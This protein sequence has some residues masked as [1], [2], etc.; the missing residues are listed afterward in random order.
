MKRSVLSPLLVGVCALV[1]TAGCSPAIP[2]PPGAPTSDLVL[3]ST[4]PGTTFEQ[5]SF[6]GK[7]YSAPLLSFMIPAGAHTVGVHYSIT[8]TDF[9][10]PEESFC[11]AT[12]S[13]G[14]CTGRLSAEAGASYRLLVDTRSSQ[15]RGT[16]S[17]RKSSHLPLG[18][19]GDV[20]AELQCKSSGNRTRQQSVGI[21]SF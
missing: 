21:A 2:I 10:G 15:P 19:D 18:Q 17:L 5:F 3:S 11:S 4:A 16:V 20:A 1:L 13:T 9:C 12:V 14:S 8:T 7:S 6:D